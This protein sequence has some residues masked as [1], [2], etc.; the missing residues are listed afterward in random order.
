ME[1]IFITFFVGLVKGL[2]GYGFWLVPP[3]LAF[4][5]LYPGVPPWTAGPSKADLLPS[6]CP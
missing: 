6:S 5:S 4:G 1:A 3:A 2:V